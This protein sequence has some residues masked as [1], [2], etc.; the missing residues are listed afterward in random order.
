VSQTKTSLLSAHFIAMNVEWRLSGF[1]SRAALQLFQCN[2]MAA[3]NLPCR[4]W[5]FG[6]IDDKSNKLT[7]DRNIF[8]EITV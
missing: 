3:S 5:L 2:S 6:Y 7:L 8:V 4:S 1:L